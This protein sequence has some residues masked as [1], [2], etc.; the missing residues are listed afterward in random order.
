MVANICMQALRR[1]WDLL[2]PF[3]RFIEIG[4][5]DAQQNGRIEL[6]PYLQNMTM[7]SVDLITMMKYRPLLLKQLIEDTVQLWTEGIVKAAEPT[8]IMPMSQA[9]EAFQTL[10][11]GKGMG[12]MVLVPHP[13]DIVPIVPARPE[14]YRFKSDATYVLSGGLGGIGRSTAKWMASRGARS[15][16]FLSSS[17]R[18][19]DAVS[20]MRVEL[21]SDGC[22]V[23][24]R[25]CDV[26]DKEALQTV[27]E[28]CKG[29]LPPIK[30][31]VQGAMKLSVSTNLSVVRL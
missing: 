13:E 19:T 27:L 11:T 7:A 25:K 21:E 5:K 2:V 28:E 1:S 16:L 23:T 24:I 3:G 12:K 29:T 4:K 20:H 8:R 15:F 31:V 18:I 26:G 10:Q 6:R 22:T 17:G 30:G 9:L 14:P